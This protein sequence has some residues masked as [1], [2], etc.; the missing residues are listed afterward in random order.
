MAKHT[1]VLKVQLKLLI[2]I[3]KRVYVVACMFMPNR[4]RMRA[5]T[6]ALMLI[7]NLVLLLS[8]QQPVAPPP[9][10]PLC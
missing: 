2:V 9:I 7:V 6:L 5:R 1:K 8:R 3:V 10:N 4:G